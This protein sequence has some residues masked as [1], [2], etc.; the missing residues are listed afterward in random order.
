MCE[1]VTH[2]GR[3]GAP[4]TNEEC[5]GGDH[6]VAVSRHL[7]I[8]PYI[9]PSVDP[10]GVEP[11]QKQTIPPVC[12][13]TLSGSAYV[14]DLRHRGGGMVWMWIGLLP[15][16]LAAAAVFLAGSRL[17][18]RA[19]HSRPSHPVLL[20]LLGGAL[21]PVLVIALT[22]FAIVMAMPAALHPRRRRRHSAVAADT[23]ALAQR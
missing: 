13:A 7:C 16:F 22:E 19:P 15:T 1:Y 4:L 18:P 21:W 2:R 9:E 6:P 3:A 10:V 20:A 8:E 14:L 5:R 23:T 17:R 12:H 11:W